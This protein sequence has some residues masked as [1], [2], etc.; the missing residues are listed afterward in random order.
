MQQGDGHTVQTHMSSNYDPSIPA[1]GYNN[2]IP[3]FSATSLAPAAPPAPIYQGWSQD[4]IS[5]PS[6]STPHNNM[7]YTGYDGNPY[8][9]QQSYPP[10]QP[11]TYHQNTQQAAPYDEGELS[12]GEFDAYGGQHTGTAAP[13]YGSNYYQGNDGTGYMSTA[14]RAVY[15]SGQDYNHQY[16]SGKSPFGTTP[17]QLIAYQFVGNGYYHQEIPQVSRQQSDSYSPYARVNGTPQDYPQSTWMQSNSAPGASHA[18]ANGTPQIKEKSDEHTQ[19]H[20]QSAPTI[21]LSDA[22]IQRNSGIQPRNS[23]DANVTSNP[24]KVHRNPT[25]PTIEGVSRVTEDRRTITPIA[26]TTPAIQTGFPKSVAEARK[27]AEGAILNLWPYEVRFPNYVE[28]GLDENIV[29]RLFDNLGFSRAPKAATSNAETKPTIDKSNGTHPENGVESSKLDVRSNFGV[30]GELR[31][32]LVE[33]NGNR[34]NTSAAQNSTSSS[35]AIT[36]APAKIEPTEKEKNLK[37]KMEA[38]RKSREVSKYLIHISFQ[39]VEGIPGA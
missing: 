32:I 36:T 27:K 12:E 29:G 13:D 18:F 1:Y 4:A 5:L 6:Y 37:M 17:F 31:G 34:V 20:T 28:E 38:L 26:Q 16:S 2:S 21:K 23:E 19:A 15:P 33:N 14:H 30:G 7:Q 39:D 25:N 35:L 11:Q 24:Q 3:S 10:P 9:T 8:Q 22:N